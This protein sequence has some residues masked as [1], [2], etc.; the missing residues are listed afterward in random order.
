M[1]AHSA[2]QYLHHKEILDKLS[3]YKDEN[4][5]ISLPLVYGNYEYSKDVEEYAKHIFSDK[6]EI[7]RER[8]TPIDYLRYIKTVDVGIFDQ[9]HQS[10]L[11]NL[12][13]LIYMD[14]KL[15]L[16]KDGI[17]KCAF[18][19]EG[20]YIETTDKL[21]LES[22]DDFIK[23]N[24]SQERAKLYVKFLLNEKNQFDMWK[25]TFDALS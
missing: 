24:D 13:Y 7:I 5:I 21:G 11:G 25:S 8:M 6:V 19:L 4:I 23:E 15:Y 17:L 16:N 9:V 18:L 3:I 10:G 14:K 20:S 22:Y 12:Y 2:H 1:I